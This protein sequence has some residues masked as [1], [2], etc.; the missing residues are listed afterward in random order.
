[1]LFLVTLDCTGS[2]SVR[3]LV[4]WS[5]RSF[6]HNVW[7]WTGYRRIFV[8]WNSE[9]PVALLDCIGE[10]YRYYCVI[11]HS[12]GIVWVG[13]RFSI[14][15]ITFLIFFL[16]SFSTT[17]TT[18]TYSFFFLWVWQGAVVEDLRVV[19]AVSWQ[20]GNFFY[21]VSQLVRSQLPWTGLAIIPLDSKKK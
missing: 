1:M 19:W 20:M 11:S 8:T 7:R 2:D 14:L 21:W 17:T 12:H 16:P 9:F 13:S 3:W 5:V 18:T 6:I 10:E 15:K 4:H